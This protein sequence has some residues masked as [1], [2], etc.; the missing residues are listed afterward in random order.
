MTEALLNQACSLFKKET[1]I[2]Q[3]AKAIKFHR[4]TFGTRLKKGISVEKIVG[5]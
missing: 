3:A 2:R 1:L 5:F 4:S